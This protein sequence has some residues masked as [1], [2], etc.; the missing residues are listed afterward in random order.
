MT[1]SCVP[2]S[3]GPG[4]ASPLVIR[5]RAMRAS[6]KTMPKK[7]RLP[8]PGE[9]GTKLLKS[10]PP[11]VPKYSISVL[12]LRFPFLL[13]GPLP[14]GRSTSVKTAPNPVVVADAGA[15]HRRAQR[16]ASP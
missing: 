8:S 11:S 1:M 2:S 7:E 12:A 16:T 3:F 15:C 6:S 13:P 5:T 14:S 4:A 9:A 10:S